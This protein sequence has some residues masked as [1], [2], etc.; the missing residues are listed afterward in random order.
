[1]LFKLGQ[2]PG[3][4][5]TLASEGLWQNLKGPT[6]EAVAVSVTEVESSSI[7]CCQLTGWHQSVRLLVEKH[8]DG[9]DFVMCQTT[10]RTHSFTVNLLALNNNNN[11]KVPQTSNELLKL[12][13]L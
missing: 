10:T 11:K 7:L 5:S 4:Q 8:T 1:M 9:H 6:S 3:P 2:Y 13:F 12:G